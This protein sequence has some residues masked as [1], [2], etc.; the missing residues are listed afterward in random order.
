MAY[1]QHAYAKAYVV[2]SLEALANQETTSLNAAQL[3][4]VDM[5]DNQTVL[6]PTSAA[7]NQIPTGKYQLTLGNYNQVDNLDGR[8]TATGMYTAHGG[9]AESIKT[10]SIDSKYVRE[11]WQSSCVAAS[12]QLI[13]IVIPNTCLKCDG[14]STDVNQLRLDIKGEETLRFLNR[15]AYSVYDYRECC[16]SGT[17]VAGSVVAAHW[18]D[19]INKDPLMSNF[20]VATVGAGAAANELILTL[21]Y[22]PTFF[23]NCSFDTRDYVGKAPLKLIVSAVNDGGDPCTD[24]CLTAAVGSPSYVAVSNFGLNN[25]T[26]VSVKAETTGETVARQVILEGRY[27]QDGGWNQGNRD[28]ARVREIEQLDGILGCAS[29]FVDRT[30]YYQGFYLLHSVP[31]FNNPTGV[32]DNDQYLYTWYLPCKTAAGETNTDLAK[33]NLFADSAAKAAGLTYQER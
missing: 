32:F 17:D 33:M 16:A 25:A 30:A 11:V 24:T 6:W 2:T 20:V 14:S 28:S 29:S 3:G 4:L 21:T 8:T 23:N 7:V 12:T 1:F 9:Y 10:K 13:K 19:R 5:S 18:K 26:A 27:R 15:F 31:R 22:T